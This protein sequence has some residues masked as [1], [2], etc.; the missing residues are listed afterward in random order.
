MPAITLTKLQAEE[1]HHKL[2]IVVDEPD[3]LESYEIS[4]QQA[5]AAIDALPYEGGEFVFDPAISDV[6]DGEVENLLDIAAANMDIAVDGDAAQLR[7]Y[8]S[9][10]TSL[11]RKIA[12]AVKQ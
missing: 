3:L 2:S 6:L 5:Q 4:E 9:S 7:A 8:M 12:K 11:R 10:L 1:L